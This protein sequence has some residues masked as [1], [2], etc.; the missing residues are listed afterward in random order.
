MLGK[1]EGKRTRGW[2]RM[3]WL[4]S[5]TDATDM[6]LSKLRETVKDRGAWCAAVR[7]VAKSQTQ[8]KDWTKQKII[9]IF[10][11]LIR[12]SDGKESACKAGDPGS[13][14]GLGRS[15]REGIGYLLQYY[16]AWPCSSVS[17]ESAYNSGDL[18]SIP[19]WGRSPG[20]GQSYPLQYSGLENSIDYVVRHKWA[21]FPFI[22]PL[23]SPMH[24]NETI[25]M[26][27]QDIIWRW[28]LKK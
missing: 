21:T 15:D 7:G 23:S 2:Q 25:S 6:N 16:W 10:L 3:K 22:L 17:E 8:F 13:V 12:G 24:K 4:D 5:I 14:P 20:E 9:G 11:C 18:G 27:K 1:I 19:G 28:S 26:Y